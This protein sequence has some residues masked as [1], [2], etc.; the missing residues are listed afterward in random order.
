MN[1]TEISA[2]GAALAVVITSATSAYISISNSINASKDAA[3]A[4]MNAIDAKAIA[5]K[6]LQATQETSEKI[7]EKTV[8]Q[9]VEHE[10]IEHLVVKKSPKKSKNEGR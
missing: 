10:K 1:S 4:K 9:T 6:T 3:I 7:D 5:S 8:I 2:I